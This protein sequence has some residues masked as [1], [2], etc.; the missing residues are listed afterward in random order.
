MLARRFTRLTKNRRMVT[1]RSVFVVTFGVCL[2][3]GAV[4]GS[5]GAVYASPPSQ[6]AGGD[7]AGS[8]FCSNCHDN[9]HSD[10][11]DT[12]HAHA[13]SSPIFQRDW[14]ELGSRTTCLACH[15]TGFDPSTGEYAEEGVT[16]E[17]CHGPF[18]LGHP[19]ENMPITPDD[20][21]C[22]TCH[23]STTDEWRTSKHAEVGIVCQ[24]C[25]DPHA[26]Q[27]K[28]ETITELCSNCH[29]DPGQ[30]FTHGTHA[31]AGLVCSNCHMYTTPRERSPIEGLVPTG[32]TFTVGSEACIGCHQ[33]TV[34]TRDVIVELTGDAVE[35]GEVDIDELQL[36]IQDQD[37]TIQDLEASS[38]VRLYL[39]LAQ[40]AIIGLVTGGVAAWIVSQRIEYVEVD[41]EGD[42]HVQ[43]EES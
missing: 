37:A 12:R 39:G 11:I 20:T 7:Y 5:F 22:E 3:M 18:I 24:A 35:R 1:I 40:G 27:P 2:T 42:E 29:Q 28:A 14:S 8:E 13:F 41:D 15:T 36:T 33:D 43:Q 21:L 16:C 23:D 34:H 26:Q 25:H 6:S 9:I 38:T 17:A 4:L 30:Q 31:Q 32:H 10:W 19:G